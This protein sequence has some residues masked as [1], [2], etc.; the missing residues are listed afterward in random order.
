MAYTVCSIIT[1]H[2]Q[3]TPKRRKRPKGIDAWVIPLFQRG[4]SLGRLVRGRVVS[5]MLARRQ[6]LQRDVICSILGVLLHDARG[7]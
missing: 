5:G 1:P 6:S 7:G 3:E 2:H 4:E